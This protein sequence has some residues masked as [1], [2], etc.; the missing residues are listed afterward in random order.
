MEEIQSTKVV[1]LGGLNSNVNHIYLSDNEPGSAIEL[2]NFEASL[3][4]GY[5]RLSGYA[6]LIEDSEFV[7]DAGA[8]GR[9]LTT[10]IFDEDIIVARKQKASSTYEFYKRDSSTWTKLTTGL[11]RSSVGV[12]KIRWRTLNF[13]G[14][15]KIVFVDGVNDACIFDGTTWTE[16][17]VANTGASYASAGGAQAI[18]A[19]SYVEVFR[20]HL[21]LAGEHLLA[22]SAP[23]EEYCFDV[24]KGAGQIPV[25]FKVMQI[26]TFR[27]TVIT[28]GIK[29]IKKVEISSTNFVLNE[30]TS[31]IGCLA[32]DSVVE[33]GGNLMF[34]S[35]DGF[36]PISGT[37]RIGD[38]ELEMVS[39]KIQQLITKQ[40]IE[41][42]LAEVSS[43]LIRGKSQVRFFF[44][45]PTVTTTSTYGIIGCLR[46]SLDGGTQWEWSRSLGIS[47][48][49]ATSSYID[50]QEY[51]IHGTYDGGVYRQET[52]NDFNGEPVVSVYSTPF[53]DFGDVGIR[54]TLRKI[55][56]F[57]RPEGVF[58]INMGIV[59]DWG[60]QEAQN[61]VSYTLD[62]GSGDL[63]FWGSSTY[64][65]AVY[66]APLSIV[67]VTNI[68]GSGMSSQLIF[69]SSDTQ[70]PYTI[71]GIVFEYSFNGR[72]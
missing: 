62:A 9:I 15:P 27:D 22:H 59:Y 63:S 41:S 54:K 21:F 39:R 20:N 48:S 6:P 69:S 68:E 17:K 36:R 50:A 13:N 56:L 45:E 43:V 67:D 58:S 71:Q 2:I 70:P 31:D 33:V 53:L 35:Q 42:D 5:R 3:Y 19:P 30:I 8:E 47:A 18:S 29:N 4:G 44:S 72:K 23:L 46:G 57:C 60:D 26:K 66:A 14:T 37:D 32:S 65:T 25:G 28:F 51:V 16:I 38:T 10:A 24:A 7:D 11:T 12:T 52:G 49:C 1:S 55:R 34:L 64:G 61:P 40:I